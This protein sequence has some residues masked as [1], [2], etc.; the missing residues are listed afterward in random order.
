MRRKERCF[1]EDQA[2]ASFDES[3]EVFMIR[4]CDVSCGRLLVDSD[5]R[6]VA[7]LVM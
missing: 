5:E 1:G 7:G 2:L 6:E 4:I 3:A